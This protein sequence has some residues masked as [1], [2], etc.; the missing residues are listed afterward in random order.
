MS[1]KIEIVLLNEGDLVAG[2]KDVTL[3]L[4]ITAGGNHVDGA[5]VTVQG[6]S[7][8]IVGEGATEYEVTFDEVK[9]GPIGIKASKI[10]FEDGELRLEVPE[11]E[12]PSEPEPAPGPEP[13]KTPIA[14][15]LL[16]SGQKGYSVSPET[17]KA[18]KGEINVLET[19]SDPFAELKLEKAR[20]ALTLIEAKVKET[21]AIL[22]GI[23]AAND[24]AGE[25]KEIAESAQTEAG[26]ALEANERTGRTVEDLKK[27]MRA[28]KGGV[29]FI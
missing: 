11:P 13:S 3:H 25:A 1:E 12:K 8:G 26:Q 19:S 17:V 29:Y 16:L 6:D 23:K 27:A 18:L 15:A 9:S 5:D 22:S 24:T 10:G 14:D 7:V 21:A 20:E 28:R 4:A 2:A